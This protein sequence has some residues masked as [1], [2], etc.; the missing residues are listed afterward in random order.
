[1]TL[2]A[3]SIGA[4]VLRSA[5]ILIL[6]VMCSAAWYVWE[7]HS[8][9]L[10]ASSERSYRAGRRYGWFLLA[11]VAAMAVVVAFISSK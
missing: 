8:A 10:V 6:G 1:M 5:T 4:T 11:F 3:S 9:Q 7:W 2:L